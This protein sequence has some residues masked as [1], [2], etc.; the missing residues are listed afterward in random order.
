[1]KRE[2]IFL[3]ST[4]PP[5]S[6]LEIGSPCN[7]KVSGPESDPIVAFASEELGRQL[8]A[9]KNLEQSCS[10]M[11]FSG[12]TV[13]HA[14]NSKKQRILFFAGAEQVTR[15]IEDGERFDFG[16]NILAFED[17]DR[18]LESAS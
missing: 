1:M 17:A 10:L 6:G 15:Y 14:E 18:I 5:D 8:I 12:L 3:V 9:G 16:G 2:L 4:P 7:I 11:L 13:E